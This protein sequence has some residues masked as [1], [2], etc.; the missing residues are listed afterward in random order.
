MFPMIVTVVGMLVFAHI[1]KWTLSYVER[2]QQRTLDMKRIDQLFKKGEE[3]KKVLMILM[4]TQLL[5][6]CGFEVVDTGY[7][8]IQTRFGE[9]TYAPLSEGLHFYNPITSTI[10]E[11]SVRTEKWAD[12]TTVFTKDTQSVDVE[13]A[14]MYAVDPNFVGDLYKQYGKEAYLE[15]KVIKP[16]I[17]GSLKDSIGQVIADELVG[18]R[19]VITRATLAATR[20][21]LEAAHV[22]VSDLQ[23]TNIDFVEAYEKAVEEKVVAIQQAQKAKNDTVRIEEEARQQ[24]KTAQAS[25]ESM[26]IKSQALSTNKGLIEFEWVQKWDGKLPVTVM[27]GA[28]PMINLESLKAK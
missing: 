7:R 27:G 22:T 3:V 23:F 5:T 26:K 19:E 13:F 17:L 4:A 16:V 8:G 20:K 12:K 1:Y 9:V 10:R 21:N 18:K 28:I 25:A 11:Y 14:V 15:E 6:A 2:K 24:I